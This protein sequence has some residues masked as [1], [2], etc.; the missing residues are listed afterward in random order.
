[1]YTLRACRRTTSI[2]V[3]EPAQPKTHVRLTRHVPEREAVAGPGAAAAGAMAE[4]AS[5]IKAQE[6]N[7]SV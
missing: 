4:T 7:A 2:T 6:A 3:V 1:M 5:A